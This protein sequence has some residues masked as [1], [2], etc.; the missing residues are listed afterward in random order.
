MAFIKIVEPDEA[1]GKLRAIYDDLLK[2]R[3]KLAE[4]HKLQ[5]LNPQSIVDH[6]DLYMTIMFGNSPLKR[7]QRE[8]MAVVV[9]RV[10]DC[11]YCQKH[12]GA[13]LEQYWKDSDR[14]EAFRKDF[15]K[16]DLTPLNRSLC[17]VADAVTRAPASKDRSAHVE[18]LRDHGL[19]DRAV[20]DSM[21]VIAYFNFVNRLVLGLGVELESDE[22][23]GYTYDP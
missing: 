9:S 8:M 5:S 6:M 3:G 18:K 2:K 16:V 17:E 21:M 10:N 23:K 11:L 7:S 12:H 4:V 1:E 22:G 14:V 20:L 13:A 19:S 15:R